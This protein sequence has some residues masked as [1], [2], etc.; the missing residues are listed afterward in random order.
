M[1][2]KKTWKIVIL[3]ALVLIVAGV[4][5]FFLWPKKSKKEIYSDAVKQSVGLEKLGSLTTMSNEYEEILKNHIIKVTVDGTS[6]NS[7]G[8]QTEK[9][10]LYYGKNQMY[11]LVDESKA[12][13]TMN[14]EAYLKDE[15]L[16]FTVKDIL[17]KYYYIDMAM[18]KLAD[19]DQKL[20]DKVVDYF[21]ESFVDALEN[22]DVVTDTKDITINSKTYKTDKYGYTFNGKTLYT[23]I[24]NFGKKIKED[25][26]LA[27]KIE[28]VI[29]ETVKEFEPEISNFNFNDFID[30][31]LEQAVIV[32][33][34]GN[35]FNYNVYLYKDEVI[36]SE[37]VLTFSPQLPITIVR[38]S[39]VENGKAYFEAYVSVMGVR[40][41]E[42][43]LNQT[44]DSNIDI[45]ISS[46]Q[47]ALAKGSITGNGNEIKFNLKTVDGYPQPFNIEGSFK[48]E[49]KL[50]ASGSIKATYTDEEGS[51]SANYNFKL[52]EVNEIPQVDVS[53]NAPYEEMP[54]SEKEALDE[55][56][57]TFKPKEVYEEPFEIEDI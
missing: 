50:K 5:W 38:N 8:E 6:S 7:E 55:L 52:E 24:Q 54:D 53:N 1:K 15:K 57:E 27:K 45:T 26:D 29:K 56:L 30:A 25:K 39:V 51:G 3:V 35:I 19:K 18:D 42:F 31:L 14:L 43:V 46:Q 21:A 34:L 23:V 36:S 9:I 2:D 48:V 11:A 10:E 16:Y 49:D 28:E 47:E 20:A 22:G 17:T 40:I 41:I 13:K 37:I 33:D 4:V 44:S 12:G 32:K